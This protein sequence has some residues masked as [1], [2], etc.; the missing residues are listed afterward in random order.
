MREFVG[1]VERRICQVETYV[2]YGGGNDET[3]GE[4]LINSRADR[5]MKKEF[6]KDTVSNLISVSKGEYASLG[7]I[8]T[9]SPEILSGKKNAIKT[10]TKIEK[11]Y[12]R[13]KK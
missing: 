1:G 13:S 5:L 4:I 11:L 7:N 2:M 12:A 6:Q 10:A 8:V 3:V 9:I